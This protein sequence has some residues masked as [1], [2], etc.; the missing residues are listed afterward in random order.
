MKY[1]L[2]ITLFTVY[3]SS[4]TLQAKEIHYLNANDL[5]VRS[6]AMVANNK[7]FVYEKGW[8]EI[9]VLQ[10]VQGPKY[11]WAEVKFPNQ[12]SGWVVSK[13]VSSIN[14]N[15]QQELLEKF[16]KESN[17]ALSQKDY[18]KLDEIYHFYKQNKTTN[19]KKSLKS[20]LAS[21]G[22]KVV[23]NEDEY[24]KQKKESW[25]LP[26]GDALY[27]GI[28]GDDAGL[29]K[30]AEYYMF[31]DNETNTF[32]TDENKYRSMYWYAKV[33]LN[34]GNERALRSLVDYYSS[35][36]KEKAHFW[37]EYSTARYKVLA[38]NG[39]V[40]A[41]HKLGEM[42]LSGYGAEQNTSIGIEWYEKASTLGSVNAM[43]KLAYFYRN[44]KEM[45]IDKA[46]YWYE[47]A[48][49]NG[50]KNANMVIGDIYFSGSEKDLSKSI[51]WYKKVQYLGAAQIKLGDLYALQND[52][53]QSE[54]W[55]DKA[56]ATYMNKAKSGESSA[57]VKV[58][59]IYILKHDFSEAKKWYTKALNNKNNSS[60]DAH[61]KRIKWM[62][63]NG[64]I[65]N[66]TVF[67]EMSF[68]PET[69]D[70]GGIEIRLIKQPNGYKAIYYSAEGEC[71]YGSLFNATLN[72]SQL[73]FKI[74][75]DV[76]FEGTITNNRLTGQF[77]KVGESQDSTTKWK[78]SGDNNYVIVD[79]RYYYKNIDLNSSRNNYSYCEWRTSP[80]HSF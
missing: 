3:L 74:S 33:A 19:I 78:H 44:S 17:E 4:N 7:K 16:N 62:F 36:D 35:K 2:Q 42:Y 24:Y 69:S 43:S 65:I 80:L 75:N 71:S 68:N 73:E 52:T 22:L 31:G 37:S 59:D 39:D 38:N 53:K 40:Q 63:K 48:A 41:M 29:S 70:V 21:N 60:Y 1:I 72:D 66:Y 18:R 46:I 28:L 14:D 11:K 50:S 58:A 57:Q 6:S 5:N 45:D 51:A 56:I 49:K 15:N 20:I 25:N 32:T 54:Y 27:R 8:S 79:D 76:V 61:P 77:K 10:E 9:E 23:L 64:Y 47:M 67:S 12:T 13:Y 55:Y 30:M 34:N 26:L